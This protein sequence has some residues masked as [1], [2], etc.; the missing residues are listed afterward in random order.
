MRIRFD[1]QL[2][3]LNE[4]MINMGNMI[5]ASIGNAVKALMKQDE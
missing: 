5:E 3:Q 4:E 1:E 2:E